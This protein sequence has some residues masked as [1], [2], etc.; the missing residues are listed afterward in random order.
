[1]MELDDETVKRVAL[2]RVRDCIALMVNARLRPHLSSHS[3]H[4]LIADV[5]VKGIRGVNV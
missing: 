3:L 5:Q 4:S 2:K 1:M